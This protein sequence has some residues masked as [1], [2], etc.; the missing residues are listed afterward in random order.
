MPSLVFLWFEQAEPGTDRQ[1]SRPEGERGRDRNQHRDSARGRAGIEIVQ[2][3]E[4][5]EINGAG[6][7]PTGSQN[8]MRHTADR[9]V[10][11]LLSALPREAAFVV[12]ADQKDRVIGTS[13]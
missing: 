4:L 13:A 5:H 6:D 12:A 11:R 3:G 8:H 1:N 7:G 9:A 2:S 10:I